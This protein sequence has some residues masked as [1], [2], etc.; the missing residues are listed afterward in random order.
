M[1]FG[2]NHMSKLN[3]TKRGGK[4]V[5]AGRK[6]GTGPYS[7]PT[8]VIRIP[9]SLKPVIKNWMDAYNNSKFQRQIREN[10]DPVELFDIPKASPLVINLP[11]YETDVPAGLLS[12][13]DD[14]ADLKLNPTEYLIDHEDSTLFVTIQGDS[15]IEAGLIPGSKAVVDRTKTPINGDIVLAMI[16]GE[17]TIKT[18]TSQKD[19]SPMLVPANFSGKYMPIIINESMQFKILGVVT[20]SFKR[21]R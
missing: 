11:H 8:T 3:Q 17:F 13:A 15:M 7:E 9:V 19:E 12:H 21:Y 5:G 16:D 1:E 18:L 6:F 10:I 14:L 4:R 2:E 20:G